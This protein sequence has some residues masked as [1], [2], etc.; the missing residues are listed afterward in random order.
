MLPDGRA[1][2]WY[3]LVKDDVALERRGAVESGARAVEA[4]AVLGGRERVRR[5]HRAADVGCRRGR[6]DADGRRDRGRLVALVGEVGRRRGRSDADGRLGRER[7]R[8]DAAGRRDRERVR[9]GAAGRRGRDAAE[10]RGHERVRAPHVEERVVRGPAQPQVPGKAERRVR[11]VVVRREHER[12]R[13][14][15]GEVE[16]RFRREECRSGRDEHRRYERRQRR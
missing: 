3:E 9:G 8:S 1:M 10:R 12:V 13:G 5:V 15:H 14:L 7:V 16:R 4:V 2:P 6:S 11:D